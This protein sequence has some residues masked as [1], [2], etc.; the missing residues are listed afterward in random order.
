MHETFG[1]WSRPYTPGVKNCGC[2]WLGIEK[3]NG[4]WQYGENERFG[5][6]GTPIQYSNWDKDQPSCD[7]CKYAFMTSDGTWRASTNKVSNT[8]CS[9]NL[10][11]GNSEEENYFNNVLCVMSHV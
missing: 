6:F 2:S 10:D 5:L 3:V 7:E 4:V 8:K 9:R 11:F 1:T